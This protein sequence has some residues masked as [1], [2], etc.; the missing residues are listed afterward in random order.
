[1]S[2]LIDPT[3]NQRKLRKLLLFS[4]KLHRLKKMI[5]HSESVLPLQDSILEEWR[6]HNVIS[7][8]NWCLTG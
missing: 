6:I 7:Q 1:M 3:T 2:L 4:L 5:K 8:T